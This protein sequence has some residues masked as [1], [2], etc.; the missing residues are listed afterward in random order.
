MGIATVKKLVLPRR[1]AGTSFTSKYESQ[2]SSA[3]K[4][5]MTKGRNCKQENNSKDF[6]H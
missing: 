1:A 5:C 4:T 3:E 6:S 2:Q